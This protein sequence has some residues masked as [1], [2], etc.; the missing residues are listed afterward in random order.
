MAETGKWLL[1]SAVCT[2]YTRLKLRRVRSGSDTRM[3]SLNDHNMSSTEKD[4]DMACSTLCVQEWWALICLVSLCFC[5][6]CVQEWRALICLVSLGFCAVCVQ[7][8]RA[9][10]CLVS[11]CFCAVCVQEW[12]ALICL[13]SLGFCAVCVQEW[14]ALICLGSLC[15]CAVYSGMAV[16]CLVSICFCACR[17]CSGMVGL[18][19]SCFTLFL[20]RVFRNGGPWYAQFQSVSVPSVFRNGGPWYA[21]F[22]SVSVPCI[23]E[24]WALICL[25]SVCFC[26]VCSGMA[27]LGMPC[28]TLFLYR[29]FRNGEP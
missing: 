8:W 5:A 4:V 7:E 1:S 28:F 21:L 14:R 10:I 23:Q 27:G 15:F 18:D 22:Q 26:A 2:L 16:T 11:L 3:Y 13:V 29:V 25:V 19:K 24:W 6:V 20:S 17:L 12:R 9:L